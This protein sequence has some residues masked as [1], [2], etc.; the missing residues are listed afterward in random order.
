M[1]EYQIDWDVL[2]PAAGYFLFA[3]TIIIVFH[4]I[5]GSD[6]YLRSKSRRKDK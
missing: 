6:D 2:R 3:R 4:H 1:L 5:K